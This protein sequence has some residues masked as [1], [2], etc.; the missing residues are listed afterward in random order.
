MTKQDLDDADVRTRF[1]QMSGKRMPQRPHRR[2]FGQA[3]GNAGFDAN[4][5]DPFGGEMRAGTLAGKQPI[6]E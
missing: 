5:E 3:G 4:L 1:Q 2:P 6:G